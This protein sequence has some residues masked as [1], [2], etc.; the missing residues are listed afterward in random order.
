MKWGRKQ[1]GFTIV[2]LLIVVVVIAILAAIT[3]VAYNGISSRAKDSVLKSAASDADKKIKQF[4]ALNNDSLPGSLEDAG[5]T[6]TT[7]VAY[8]YTVTGANAFCLT[9]SKDGLAA[10]IANGY[11]YN[12]GTVLTQANPTTGACPGHSVAGGTIIK[13]LAINPSYETGL[14]GW[15][16]SS[17]ASVA[18]STGVW[19]DSG[20]SSVRITNTSTTNQGDFRITNG[21]NTMPFGMEPGKTYTISARLYFTAAP[22]GALGR[23]PGILYWYSTNG[24]AWNEAF[25]PKAPTAPGTY[26]VSHTVTLPANATGVLIAFGAAS[27]TIN[28]NFYYDSF[29]ITEGTT[30]YG[31]GDGA[32]PNWVW[33][34]TPQASA[35]TGPAG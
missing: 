6:S 5:L 32:S 15:S 13:N 11:T 21:A 29:M 23:A 18:P 2:E 19:A 17:G 27:T 1:K 31:Y 35:S 26:T 8:Q 20:T 22:T 25:G 7:G 24:S 14:T 3:I 16:N 12:G 4:L 10:Y 33:L 9:A 28:Q 34:G 30:S